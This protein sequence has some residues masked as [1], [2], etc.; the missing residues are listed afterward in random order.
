MNKCHW[1]FMYSMIFC[2]IY[3][4]SWN[5]RLPH[6]PPIKGCLGKIPG[7][8]F[9]VLVRGAG[10]TP[11]SL[12]QPHRARG[13]GSNSTC[14]LFVFSKIGPINK[15]LCLPNT[16]LSP[17]GACTKRG[18]QNFHLDAVART[19]ILYTVAHF[20]IRS[21]ADSDGKQGG[22]QYLKKVSEN[23]VIE[24]LHKKYIIPRITANFNYFIIH[25]FP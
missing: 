17:L 1:V 12:P 22:G 23:V 9:R 20:T 24:K 25:S 14:G 11:P 15:C 16:Y 18:T 7:K 4:E 8:K 13:D 5:P 6:E 21:H 2:S 19:L 3:S 10:A